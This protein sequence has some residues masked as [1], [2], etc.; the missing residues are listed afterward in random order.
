MLSFLKLRQE[1]AHNMGYYAV[2]V[3]E[4]K[5]IKDLRPYFWNFPLRFTISLSHTKNSHSFLLSTVNQ[6][7]QAKFQVML[8]T[9]N[10]LYSSN[11]FSAVLSSSNA[12]ELKSRHVFHAISKA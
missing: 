6:M 1:T 12:L 10:Y 8:S 7:T 2:T 9:V 11:T 3:S 4:K 5:L